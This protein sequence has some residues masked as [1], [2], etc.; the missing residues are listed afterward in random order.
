MKPTMYLRVSTYEQR[1]KQ[2]IDTQRAFAEWFAS[3]NALCGCCWYLDD[4]VSGTIPLAEGP[5]GARLLDDARAGKIDAVFIYKLDRLGRDARLILN[6]MNELESLGVA[7]RSMTE[8]LDTGSPSGKFLLTVLSGA[9]GLEHDTIIQRS[10][11]GSKQLAREGTWLGGIVLYGYRAVGKDRNSRLAISDQPI[12]GFTL[13]EEDVVRLIYRLTMEERQ[14][15]AFIADYLNALGV[16]PVYTRDGCPLLRGK[17]RTVTYGIWR[18]GRIRGMLDNP[19]YKGLHQYG[20]RSKN[21]RREVIEREVPAII[22]VEQW[23]RARA[24]ALQQAQRETRM[25]AQR[26]LFLSRF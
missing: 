26:A 22:C 13:S 20:K 12:P 17:S 4:G 6:C 2:T 15:C 11:E 18:A 23:E 5:E 9:A 8:P 25:P 1:K 10:V 16:P 19:T 7:V 24:H 14:S 3:S 21:R